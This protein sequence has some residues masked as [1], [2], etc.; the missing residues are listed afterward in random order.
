MEP[1]LSD[2]SNE[3]KTQVNYINFFGPTV[4][5]LLLQHIA[6][7][8]ADLSNVR[9]KQPGVFEFF[10]VAPISPTQVLTGKF[11]SFALLLLFR[12][13]SKKWQQTP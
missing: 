8:L 7:T 3:V 13:T 2:A 6:V 5:I 1:I 4:V 9:D 10:R 12:L 11:I